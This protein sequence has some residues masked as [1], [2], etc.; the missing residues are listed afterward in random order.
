[1]RVRSSRFLLPALLWALPAVVSAQAAPPLSA[2]DLGALRLRNIGPA[3]M[4][5]RVVDMDVV[6]S[7]PSTWYVAG[8]TGGLWRTEDNGVTWAST[9]DAPV[10]SIGDVAV[11]Q[12]NPQI[13]W[14]GTGERASRQSVGWG[15]GVYKSTDGGKTWQNM[16]LA[17]SMHIGRIQ[18]HPRDP[19][20]AYVAAQGSVWG[21]GGERGL[22]RTTDGG[23]SWTRTL[24]VDDET[25]ATDVAMDWN[26]PNVLYAATYQRRRS[27]YGFDGGGPGSALWKSIDAG[28]TWTKLTGHG[29]PEGEYGRIGIGVYRKNPKILTVSIEQGARYN[30]STAYIV[31][32]AGVYRSEDAGAT[33]TFMSDWNPRPMYA[34][35]VI[36][37]PNDDQRIYMLNAYSFS[38]NGGKTF[39]APRTTTHGDDRFV[40]VNPANSRHVVKLDDG[41]IGISYDRGNKFLYVTSLPLSQFYRVTTDN[42]V[43]FNIYGGL[44]DNGCWMGPSASW[45]TNGV[46]N[47][48][49]SRLC[50]GDGF[51]VTPNPLN[52]RTVNMGL[53]F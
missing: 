14:V 10:H 6:E 3:S 39:T 5:G 41:G 1:M 29:L 20:I 48:H 21:A 18:L 15:D 24:A 12:P 22:Y 19:N 52:S 7:N 32:K 45:N 4:S 26:D 36:I 8:A 49:F 30:A 11:F 50:G 35:Q 13:L 53:S 51:H 16:G 44:Q 38:D 33:W 46:L 34:S 31:R 9:F 25:G 28:A 42:A 37:D 2:A 17:T 40:W 43:P 47:D 27:A 23:R